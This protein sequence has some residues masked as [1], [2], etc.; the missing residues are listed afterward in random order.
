[1]QFRQTKKHKIQAI[2]MLLALF[3]VSLALIFAFPALASAQLASTEQSSARTDCVNG[4]A[5]EFS[6]KNIDLLSHMS[7]EKLGDIG[8]AQDNWGWRDPQTGRYYAIV[9]MFLGTSFVDVTD[10]VNPVYLGKMLSANRDQGAASDVKTY[11][12][13]AFVVSSASNTGMQVFDL[14]RLRDVD[15]PQIFE[16]DVL[17]TDIG[18]AHN[19]AINEETGYAYLVGGHGIK[20]CGGDLHIVDIR[21]PKSPTW[22]G[23]YT[24]SGNIHDS[25]CVIYRG[26]DQ[27]YQGAEICFASNSPNLSIIDVSDKDN[28]SLLGQVTW[29]QQNLAHQ[30]WLTGDQRYF[31]IGDEGDEPAFDLNTR[32]IVLDVSDL[33]NPVYVG[34]YLADT[35]A[36]DHNQYVIGDYVYQANY[37]VGLRIL[38]IDD[39]AAAALTEVAWFDTFPASD[40]LWDLG[41]W[42]VY[43]FFDNGTLLVSDGANGLFMLHAGVGNE[44]RIKAGHAGAWFNPATLGQGQFIDIEPKK[45]FMFISWFTYTDAASNNPREQ[46]W[47]TAQGNYNG[48]TAVLDLFE[49][50]G[51]KFD[52]TQEVTRARIGEV[53][54]SFSDCEQGLMSYSFDEEELQGEFPLNRVIPGSGNLCGE[55]GGNTIQAVDINAGM[56][57]AWFDSDTPG[58][59]FFIDAHTDPE[60]SNFI[61]VS[62]FTFGE[63]TAS[64]QRWLTAQGGFED[65]TAEIDVWETTGGSFDDPEPV[66][67]TKVGTMSLDFTDCSNAQLT[68]SLPADP[69][70]GDI[71]I[72]RVIP[73]SQALCEQLVG[74]D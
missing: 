25:Q 27:N 36:I 16:P 53:T 50:L 4:R 56:D 63:Q 69:A 71:A 15:N 52:D 54:L 13:H 51:G 41:A 44:S 20:Q 1:M 60:G 62:W 38:H 32:T 17:Y 72:T 8:R 12:N 23:C 18:G 68:Y 55:L 22:I 58:Q 37:S 66:G 2:V 46:H 59:G 65:S 30:G 34:S 48:N 29:P 10:P 7:L 45:Q 14:T 11:A 3:F 67:R 64:G 19:I 42:N 49:T 35:T 61:F 9:S 70:E 39:L 28:I 26:P 73:G 5:G 43:P 24:I 47:Y 31:L 21:T 6:C 40:D 57:G 33:E 74:V